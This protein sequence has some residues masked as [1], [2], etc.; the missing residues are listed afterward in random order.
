MNPCLRCGAQRDVDICEYC[1][2]EL[3]WAKENE[4]LD[5]FDSQDENDTDDDDDD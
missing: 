5:Y 2:D 4:G 3:D 1:Q